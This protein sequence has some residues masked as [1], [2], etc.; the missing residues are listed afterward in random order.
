[1]RAAGIRDPAWGMIATQWLS[2]RVELLHA[3]LHLRHLLAHSCWRPLGPL[4]RT[5]T[6]CNIA[7]LCFRVPV[8]PHSPPDGLEPLLNAGADVYLLL[9]QVSRPQLAPGS[10]GPRARRP[11]FTGALHVRI[12]Y[13]EKLHVQ[14]VDV[15]LLVHVFVPLLPP[16]GLKHLVPEGGLGAVAPV[17]G[18]VYGLYRLQKLHAN[19]GGPSEA[20]K[21][22]PVVFAVHR[23]RPP[24]FPVAFGVV[25][26]RWR[27]PLPRRLLGG[28]SLFTLPRLFPR[29][30]VPL[31]LCLA[32]RRHLA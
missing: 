6:F 13:L 30:S 12:V 3:I 29:H 11:S 2:R 19:G 25:P 15:G 24:A 9:C 18:D 14:G 23:A 4:V 32:S 26:G 5:V 21:P 27:V 31:P 8:G 20:G 17:L 10:T 22:A 7:Q 1:M 16:E 28:R